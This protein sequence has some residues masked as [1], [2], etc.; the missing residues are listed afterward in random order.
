MFFHFLS[1]SLS[2]ILVALLTP[3]TRYNIIDI[4]FRYSCWR[5]D[6]FGDAKFFFCPN[7]FKFCPIYSLL[8]FLVKFRFNFAKISLKSNQICPNLIKFAFAQ[9]NFS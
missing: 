7:L 1:P 9:Q 2:K 3:S 6:V 8:S 4:I 5:S